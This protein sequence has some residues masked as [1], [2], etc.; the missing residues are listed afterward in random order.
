MKRNLKNKLQEIKPN[1]IINTAAMTQVDDCENNKEACD[2]LN[3][4]VVKWL[5]EFLKK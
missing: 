2:L 3:V 1:F 4:T 5:S